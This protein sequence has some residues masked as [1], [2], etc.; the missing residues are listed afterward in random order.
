MKLLLLLLLLSPA[1]SV[2]CSEDAASWIPQTV[3][4]E[5]QVKRPCCLANP[6]FSGDSKPVEVM[7]TAW[8]NTL[9]V[10][11]EVVERVS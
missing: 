9:K 10:S 3:I 11:L 8:K 6:K 1:V 4:V 2:F 5:Q 7:L